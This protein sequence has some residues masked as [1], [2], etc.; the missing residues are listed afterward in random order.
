MLSVHSCPL[1][2]LGGRDTGG[3]NVY[4]RELSKT[5]GDKGHT[6]DIYTRAHDPRD[7]QVED[8]AQN[9]NLVHI[10]AGRVED[11]AKA[12]Q[13][14]HLSAF[15]SNL[16]DFRESNL[17]QYDLIHSHYWL[18]G[19]V[20]CTLS[21]MWQVKDVVMYHTVGAVKN[22]FEIGITET[23]R[24]LQTEQQIAKNCSR[25]ITA[26]EREKQDIS[27][28]YGVASH[29]IGVVP[30]GVN[31]DLFRC[32]NRQDARRLLNLN[33]GDIVLY[34][35]RIDPLKGINK[36][37]E[38]IASLNSEYLIKL[39]IIGGDD[40]SRGEIKRL[41][42]LSNNLGIGDHVD[43]LGSVPQ[44][45][46]PL[47]YNA[48]DLCV[49][50]SYYETFGLVSLEALACGTPVVSTDVGASTSL[51][52]DDLSGFIVGDNQPATLAGKIEQ[53]LKKRLGNDKNSLTIR[54]S[55][56]QYNWPIIADRITAQYEEVL[57]SSAVP[58]TLN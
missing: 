1:G 8:L 21:Q 40:Y 24:R 9:V 5:L 38:A 57:R 44:E 54:N 16:E 45:Q 37:I 14:K 31:L 41:K 32:I 18:S 42:H 34:V 6:V 53:V 11:M 48:A 56:E 30:C 17:L 25:I 15:T 3:M 27:S 23:A 13:Y 47:Y 52:K 51:I 36:L 43:F 55:I 58:L 49:T 29:K 35:G 22:N 19:K 33:G 10:R 28:S 7:R 39:I 46:L 50:P 4:I 20:G 2:Q 26:T 12:A